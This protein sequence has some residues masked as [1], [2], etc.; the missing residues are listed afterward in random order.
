M[1]STHIGRKLYIL[2]FTG[3]LSYRSVW[4]TFPFV[5]NFMRSRVIMKFRQMVRAIYTFAKHRRIGRQSDIL[6]HSLYCF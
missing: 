3:K 1:L 2:R 5:D 4:D 6:S